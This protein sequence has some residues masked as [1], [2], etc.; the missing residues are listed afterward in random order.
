MRHYLNVQQQG[1]LG[2]SP[3]VL[4]VF[5]RSLEVIIMKHFNGIGKIL[6]LHVLKRTWIREMEIK[7]GIIS[8]LSEWPSSKSQQT[9]ASLMVQWLRTY[10]STAT[11]T[12]SIHGRETVVPHV[13]WHSQKKPINNMCWKGCGE[14]GNHLHL[15]AH[16]WAG[17]TIIENS[18]EFP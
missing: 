18:V 9:W 4:V 8:Y 7:W 6:C 15:L 10:A 14:K 17:I 1:A 11:G 16:L 3:F 5:C 13:P 12:K 2:D